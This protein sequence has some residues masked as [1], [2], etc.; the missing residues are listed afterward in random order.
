MNRQSL[1]N[2]IFAFLLLTCP[3]PNT[4]HP[5]H[6]SRAS[7]SRL[8][9]LTASQHPA[10]LFAGVMS[11]GSAVTLKSQQSCSRD[12]KHRAHW[13][14]LNK[15]RAQDQWRFRLYSPLATFV[16]TSFASHEFIHDRP[17]LPTP[18]G[19]EWRDAEWMQNNICTWSTEICFYSE[20]GDVKDIGAK[21]VTLQTN[22]CVGV[23]VCFGGGRYY[24]SKYVEAQSDGRASHKARRTWCIADGTKSGESNHVARLDQNI[25]VLWTKF[26]RNPQSQLLFKWRIKKI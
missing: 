21:A 24:E 19:L 11:S 12:G 5:P 7:S 13:P 1:D 9:L 23:C 20:V 4:A 16:H 25:W 17:S 14:R 8:V 10:P 26:R 2:L 15:S 22:V 6:D 3:P 18:C